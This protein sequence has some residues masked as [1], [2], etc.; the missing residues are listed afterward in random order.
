MVIY[1]CFLFIS[2]LSLSHFK[3]E[4]CNGFH[5]QST[6]HYVSLDLTLA[7]QVTWKI[8]CSLSLSFYKIEKK[9]IYHLLLKYIVYIHI[10]CI[11]FTYLYIAYLIHLMNLNSV[12]SP[13]KPDFAEK[14]CITNW[15]FSNITYIS[16]NDNS[17]LGWEIYINMSN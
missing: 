7:K 11:T 15:L 4:V 3:W 2:H 14:C 13:T 1:Q 16:I 9:I 6:I 8:R 17:N 12:R 5:L 10:L